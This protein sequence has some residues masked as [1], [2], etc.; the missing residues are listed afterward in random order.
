VVL[1][2]GFLTWLRQPAP[3]PY[4]GSSV[5]KSLLLQVAERQMGRLSTSTAQCPRLAKAELGADDLSHCLPFPVV[6]LVLEV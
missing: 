2:E 1:Y 4:E 5:P 3:G 6:V